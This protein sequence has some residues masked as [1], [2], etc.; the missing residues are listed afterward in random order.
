M[1]FLHLKLISSFSE[2]ERKP[3][4][5]H[6]SVGRREYHWLLKCIRRLPCGHS[7]SNILEIQGCTNC[8]SVIQELF[9]IIKIW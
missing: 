2:F 6:I 8:Q 7:S 5:V 1:K 4:V 9:S 3:F